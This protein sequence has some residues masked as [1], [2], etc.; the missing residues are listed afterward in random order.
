LLQAAKKEAGDEPIW[1]RREKDKKAS[2]SSNDLPFGVY[3]LLSAIVAIAAVCF[4]TNT[5]TVQ[6]SFVFVS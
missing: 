5:G 2:E 3:L 6:S 1:V 4:L